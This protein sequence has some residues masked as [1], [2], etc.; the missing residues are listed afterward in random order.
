MKIEKKTLFILHII[1]INFENEN[2]NFKYNWSHLNEIKNSFH[3]IVMLS[4]LLYLFLI[5]F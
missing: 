4:K 5:I 2:Y 1:R 3:I